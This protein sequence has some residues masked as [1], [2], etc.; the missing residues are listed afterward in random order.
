MGQV[1]HYDS[2]IRN[3]VCHVDDCSDQMPGSDSRY[4]CTS[5]FAASCLR[6][7]HESRPC[8]YQSPDLGPRYF[9]NESRGTA[10]SHA[11]DPDPLG[12]E[13]DP[14][15]RSPTAP[16]INGSSQPRSRASHYRWPADSPQSQSHPPRRRS[17]HLLISIGH[18]W[19]DIG[20][21]RSFQAMELP[22]AG[23]VE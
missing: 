22:R 5:P 1:V 7:V 18:S 17:G 15:I 13:S 20:R 10:D 21:S 4:Q 14:G 8:P 2:Q 11:A 6:P 19:L 9:H 3:F 16:T 23:R 12:T